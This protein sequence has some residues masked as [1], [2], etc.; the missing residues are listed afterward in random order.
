MTNEGMLS[1]LTSDIMK[2]NAC[3]KNVTDNYVTIGQILSETKRRETIEKTHFKGYKNIAEFAL[4]EFGF[5][6][7]TTYNLIAVYEKFFRNQKENLYKNFKYTHLVYMLTMTEEQLQKCNFQMT[8]REIKEIKLSLDKSSN[9]LDAETVA[10][11]ENKLINNVIEG[12]FPDKKF[13]E[14]PEQKQ[15]TIIITELPKPERVEN[16]TI[17]IEVKS[18]QNNDF[19]TSLE[20]LPEDFFKQKYIDLQD[21]NLK[22][23]VQIH[24]LEKKVNDLESELEKKS[25]FL[26][27]HFSVLNYVYEQLSILNI[28]STEKLKEEL[29]DF[30][31]FKKLPSKLD[32][33]KNVI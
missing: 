14:E 11:T 7:T 18:E 15:N 6:R 30:I 16:K 25:D 13:D 21:K 27:E 19:V 31:K 3:L 4:D 8:V 5:E 17:T 29:Y 23:E 26:K 32:F 22:Y 9:R 1:L 10:N 12:V 2:I 24:N 20:Q 28:K 33:Y